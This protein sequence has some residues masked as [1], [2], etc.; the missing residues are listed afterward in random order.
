M[1]PLYFPLQTGP[2]QFSVVVSKLSL[3]NFP[4]GYVPDLG[5]GGDW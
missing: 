1:G 3:S 5:G 2:Q 4:A